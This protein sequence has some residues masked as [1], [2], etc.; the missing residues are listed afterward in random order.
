MEN[1]QI[2]LNFKYPLARAHA[3]VEKSRISQAIEEVVGKRLTNIEAK[4]DDGSYAGIDVDAKLKKERDDAVSKAKDAKAAL[5]ELIADSQKNNTGSERDREELEKKENELREALENLEECKQNIDQEKRASEESWSSVEKLVTLTE[6]QSR[7]GP[8]NMDFSEIDDIVQTM[9]DGEQKTMA[10][11]IVGRLRATQK[12]KERIKNVEKWKTGGADQA[13]NLKEIEDLR[14]EIEVLHAKITTA[15]EARERERKAAEEKKKAAKAKTKAAAEAKKKAAAEKKAAADA[16][17]DAADATSAN[18]E[19][20]TYAEFQEANKSLAALNSLLGQFELG[21]GNETSKKGKLLQGLSATNP[22]LKLPNPGGGR[23]TR[24]KYHP[25]I[26]RNTAAYRKYIALKSKYNL[27][28]IDAAELFLAILDQQGLVYDD[29]PGRRGETLIK[30]D[31]AK[32]YS[33]A[34]DLSS[35][36]IWM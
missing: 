12:L 34:F 35:M 20:A 16:A 9:K 29:G 24:S 6:Q 4:L 28:G 26:I 30:P 27:D 25:R 3:L 7:K 19:F 32:E 18:K 36:F 31:L 8:N 13:N 10:E 5:D 1:P 21:G 15:A 17:A 23:R 33:S 11:F 14:A 2:P 22:S